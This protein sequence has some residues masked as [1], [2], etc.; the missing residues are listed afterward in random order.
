[1]LSLACQL[2][3]N[4]WILFGAIMAWHEKMEYEWKII[5]L[6]LPKKKNHV[7]S[8]LGFNS[9]IT[10]NPRLRKQLWV[11]QL[12]IPGVCSELLQGSV[13]THTSNG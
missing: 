6:A 8:R 3:F 9:E 2:F 1:M 5:F 13:Q 10:S 4:Q 12:P 11:L 7:K